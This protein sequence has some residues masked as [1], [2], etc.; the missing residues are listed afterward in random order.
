MPAPTLTIETAWILQ[1]DGRQSPVVALIGPPGP[2]GPSTEAA[3]LSAAEAAASA[4]D[5]QASATAAAASEAGVAADA[6]AADASA[7]AAAGSASTASTKAGEAS[8]SADAAAASALAAAASK[9]AAAISETNAAGSAAT[10]TTKAGEASASAATATSKAGEASASAVTAT[11][12]AATATA[13]ADEATAQAGIATTQA[14][15]A[16]TKAGEAAISEVNAAA[17]AATANTKAGEASGSAASAL[18][19]YGS[20][21]AQQAAVETAQA[22]ASLAAGYAASAASVMQQDLSGV[23]A[24]ALHRSPNAITA[25]C[26]YDTSKDSDGG[27]WTERCQHTSWWNEALNGK[28]LGPQA[29]E[30]AARAVAGAATG[31]YFQLSGDGEFYKL[32]AGAGTTEVH[33]GNK[34]DFPRLAAIVA[35][36]TNV[37]IYDLTEPGRPMWMRFLRSAAVLGW[38]TNDNSNVVTSLA[39][40]NGYLVIGRTNYGNLE[41]NFVS[42]TALNRYTGSDSSFILTGIAQRTATTG[43]GPGFVGIPGIA[44]STVNAVAMTVLPDAPV[45]P[46]TGLRVP[47]I[48]VATAGGVSVI[49]HNG[50]VVSSSV[51]S[52]AKRVRFDGKYGLWWDNDNTTTQYAATYSVASFSSADMNHL[53]SGSMKIALPQGFRNITSQVTSAG[54]AVFANGDGVGLLRFN[55]QASANAL[56]SYINSRFNTGWMAGDIR[57][58]LLSD[59]VTGALTATEFVTNG[60]NEAALMGT[61]WIA[62]PVTAE[63]GTV[64]RSTDRASSGSA[65]AKYTATSSTSTSHYITFG[66]VPA[67]V[68]LRISG[69]AYLPSGSLARLV[70]TDIWDGSLTTIITSVTKDAW[71]DFTIIRSAKARAWPLA[72]GN[73]NYESALG[74]TFHLDDVSI[75]LAVADRSYKAQGAAI[76]GSL[77]RAQLASGTSLVAFSGWSAANYL[78]EP[79]SADLDFG[80]G[81]WTASAWVNI[82]TVVSAV[83]VIAE[84]AGAT[85]PS[86]RL[87]ID[88]TGK[89]VATAY[90]GTT[91][92]TV[93]TTASYNTAQWI[94]ARVNY[95]TDGTLAI[96]VNGREVATARGAPLL[97]LNNAAA[98]LT[99]GNSYALDAPFPGSLA[100][101]K[102]GATVPTPEQAVFM[103]EQEKQLF[104]DGAISVLPDT[105][106]IVDMAYD[107]ATDRWVAISA[108]NES[109]WSGLVRAS[110]QAVPAGSFTRIAAGAGV[111]LAAR[112]TTNPGV[113]VTIPAYGLREELVRRAEA[114]ARL[115]KEVAIYDF[116]GGFTANTTSG[117]TAITSVAGLSYPTSAIGARVSGA[118]VPANTTIVGVSG[119]TIYLSA[120]C[121]ATATGVSVSF[122]DFILPVG[123]EAKAVLS[124]G[125]LKQEGST[126][127]YTRL[128]DGFRETIRFA[129]AP[130]VTAW[131]QVQATRGTVQ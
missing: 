41:I 130:G 64:E 22:Q 25:L 29:S 109:Y 126:K 5:A 88:A 65:S 68:G 82:P 37:T 63:D 40:L 28:W 101:L 9:N 36:A 53:G 128:F 118:G 75:T 11:S 79:Y 81:E 52:A 122:L 4:L 124:A 46:V 92:R 131:V 119:T 51:T 59:T 66:T 23:A 12:G 115:S 100:L 78:R 27:A 116:V 32:N 108:A 125:A 80:T 38:W 113:D 6:S 67:G 47:T 91:T 93:T 94:K 83:G 98:V 48:A 39:M 57:R 95:T 49:R 84:R 76:N 14:G 121:T 112:S 33:R 26:I 43:K 3:A 10:S 103:Y 2:M 114:A 105:G 107:E 30:A 102:L 58:C 54:N 7:T 87:A 19:I 77:T 60:D 20:T 85:G 17:S 111:E 120:A 50:T 31:D 18:A 99:I 90:D 56:S 44:N 110:A 13:K 117:S 104:R 96:L 15:I 127:D 24:Q 70:A 16:T 123:L 55:A 21:A 89:L 86:I 72:I 73:N 62:G 61:T 45:D 106:A 8:D 97:T 35:E 34:R 42:D 129:V 1:P 69:K 74:A 71:V